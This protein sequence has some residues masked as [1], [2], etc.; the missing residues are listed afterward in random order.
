MKCQKLNS[1]KEEADKFGHS[2]RIALA[3]ILEANEKGIIE[4]D[5]KAQPLL[6]GMATIGVHPTDDTGVEKIKNKEWFDYFEERQDGTIYWN[7]KIEGTK[8]TD[9]KK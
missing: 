2:N 3:T 7:D 4:S 6:A 8:V 5:F 1:L 9:A